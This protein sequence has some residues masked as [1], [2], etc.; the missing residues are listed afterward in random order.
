MTKG[1]GNY[2][3][4]AVARQA[5]PR[6]GKSGKL[7]IL[8]GDVRNTAPITV[9]VL[10]LICDQEHR[11]EA[12]FASSTAFEDQQARG[13]VECPHCG[14][15][16]LRRLP[17]APYVQRSSAGPAPAPEARPD[18]RQ[19]LHTLMEAVRQSARNSEDVGQRFAEEAR[20][21][22]YGDAEDR[23]IRGRSRPE[24][25]RSLLDEGIPV[26]PVP[27]DKTDLH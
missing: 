16:Q 27:P 15:H 20:K 9:I 8:N 11:F 1:S 18:P 21:I 22:H 26:L 3:P 12:W 24:E 13:L 2:P 14:S 19:V 7:D 10:D 5:G 25:I 23:A 17:S 6:L 4:H